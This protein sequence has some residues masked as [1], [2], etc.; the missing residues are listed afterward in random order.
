MPDYAEVAGCSTY[1]NPHSPTYDNSSYG[2]YATTTLIGHSKLFQYDSS[3]TGTSSIGSIGTSP[4]PST[5]YNNF[6]NS[7]SSTLASPNKMNII[8]N[9][10][11]KLNHKSSPPPNGVV[12]GD[13]FLYQQQQQQHSPLKQHIVNTNNMI[14]NSHCN[15]GSNSSLT[16]SKP[17][18]TPTHNNGGGGATIKS[19][20]RFNNKY[21]EKISFGDI[22]GKAINEQPLFIKSKYDGSWTSVNNTTNSYHSQQLGLDTTVVSNNCS[23]NNKQHKNSSQNYLSSFGKTGDN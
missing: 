3:K 23:N 6:I 10:M 22:N 18:L 9:R 2:A 20:T 15:N 17:H 4:S 13:Q 19:R 14:N 21:N 16:T 1:Q 11:N 7:E 8:E 12:I 5:M